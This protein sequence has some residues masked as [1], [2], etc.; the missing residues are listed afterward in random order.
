MRCLINVRHEPNYHFSSG[1]IALAFSVTDC[2]P[3]PGPLRD[4]DNTRR[5]QLSYLRQEPAAL[6]SSLPARVGRT[7]ALLLKRF[8]TCDAQQSRDRLVMCDK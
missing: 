4:K 2:G 8:R 6:S 7:T 3:W 5:L 1:D